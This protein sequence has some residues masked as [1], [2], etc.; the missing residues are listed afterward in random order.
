VASEKISIANVSRA[1]IMKM[2][3][4]TL[5]V[6]VLANRYHMSQEY[7][8]VTFNLQKLAE[9]GSQRNIKTK[10]FTLLCMFSLPPQ[11]SRACGNLFVIEISNDL[12]WTCPL[13]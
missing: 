13:L 5:K 6:I 2:A 1:R 10:I 7:C 11:T 8:E 4:I 9:A 3:D 12:Q